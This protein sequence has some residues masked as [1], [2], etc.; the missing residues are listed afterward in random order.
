MRYLPRLF[1]L[2]LCLAVLFQP[3]ASA[4]FEFSDE[5]FQGEFTTE[6]LDRIIQEYELFDGWYWTTP[7]NVPQTFHGQQDSPGWTDTAERANRVKYVKGMYG[8]RWLR[9][10][11][12]DLSPKNGYGECFGFAMFI[13]YLLSGEKNPYT[14]WKK[15][16]GLKKSNGLRV[17]DILRSE[18]DFYGKKCAHS[19]IVY[20]VTDDEILFLQVSGTTYNKISVGTGFSDVNFGYPTTL[21]QL[22]KIPGTKVCRAPQNTKKAE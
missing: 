13:G 3:S 8:C 19:A 6:N 11:V 2:I 17:G 15:Y 22:L 18:Y 16:Y 21:D 10:Q 5:R 12:S 20:S 4:L 1:C 14:G 7:A 9:D